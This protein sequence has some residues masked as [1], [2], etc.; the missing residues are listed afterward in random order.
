M[1]SYNHSNFT[2]HQLP[3]L[4]DNYIYL[5]EAHAS[6]AL[7]VI[8]PAE[9]VSVRRACRELGKPLTHIFNTHHHWDHTDGNQSLKKDFGAVVIGAAHD[10][11]RIPGI[12]LKVSEASPP[13]VDGLNIR[14]LDVAGHTRGHIAYLLDDALFCGDTLFGAGCGRLFE[15]TPAQMWQSLQK[16]AQLDGNTRIYCAHEYTLAN[17]AFAVMV[18]P[19]NSTLKERLARDSEKRQQD[20]P[21]IPSTIEIEKAT[22]PFLRPLDAAFLS[23]YAA[24]KAVKPE[25]LAVFTHIRQQ[26]DHF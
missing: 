7:I 12:D 16:I 8:D 21:T 20:I 17:L 2:V 6:S 5:I 18:D 25:A 26:K 14:V 24:G 23:A 19:E 9:A 13:L 1:L 11:E 10:A 3:V 15:G 22:N 4:K